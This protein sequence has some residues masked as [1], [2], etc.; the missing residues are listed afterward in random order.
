MGAA[1]VDIVRLGDKYDQYPGVIKELLQTAKETTS[2]T[3][4]T[5]GSRIQVLTTASYTKLHA[6]V[7]V[8]EACWLAVGAD[9][10]AADAPALS[11]LLA[12]NT[13]I[14]VPVNP[15]DKLSFKD[16]A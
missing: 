7:Q 13:P 14:T 2:T 11:Y 8:D 12:A 10:T 5:A 16:V 6:R 1:R 15:G 3:A 9:P 4:T